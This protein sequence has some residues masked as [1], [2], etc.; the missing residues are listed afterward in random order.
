MS[1]SFEASVRMASL[2]PASVSKAGNEIFL[3]QPPFQLDI[4][5]FV[6]HRHSPTHSTMSWSK[7]G[8]YRHY[9]RPAPQALDARREASRIDTCDREI[10]AW[11]ATTGGFD[12]ETVRELMLL[13]VER[14]FGS[15]HTPHAVEW[16]TDGGNC[17]TAR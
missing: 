1:A 13:C 5:L 2:R 8:K 16:L 6:T 17:Y 10:I 7:N 15:H 11:G 12:N 14:R 4:V 3:E 9:Q